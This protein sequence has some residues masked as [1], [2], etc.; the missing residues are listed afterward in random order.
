MTN[1]WNEKKGTNQRTQQRVDTASAFMADENILR[2]CF[3]CDKPG[4]T[5]NN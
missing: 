3:N 2:K 4:N 5:A 1:Y